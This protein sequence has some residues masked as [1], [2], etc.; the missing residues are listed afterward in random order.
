MSPHDS[1]D[2]QTA[3]RTLHSLLHAPL[4]G[5]PAWRNVWGGG[6][7]LLFLFVL[8]AFTG[9][10]MMTVY[11]PSATTAWSSVWYIQTQVPYGW[12]IRGLH[13]FGSDAMLV[14]IGLHCLQMSM[15]GAY[16]TPRQWVWWLSL[17]LC[18]LALC[19][20]LTGHLLPWDQGGYWSTKVRTNIVARTPLMGEALR[21]LLIGGSELGQLTLT[22]FY[23]LHV[24]VIP[25]LVALFMAFR[26]ALDT[27]ENVAKGKP[28]ARADEGACRSGQLLRGS[29]VC[30]GV[31]IT[32]LVLLWYVRGIAGSELLDAPADPA[33]ADYPAR[34]EWHTLFLYKWLS[35]F[36]GPLGG[37][38]GAIAV[39][40]VVIV[41]FFA[42]PFLDRVLPPRL[43]RALALGSVGAL[44]TGA[45]WLTVLA[46]R[47]DLNP[48]NER[49]AAVKARQARGETLTADHEAILR[50]RRFN[51]RRA[52]ARQVAARAM[53][54]AAQKGVPPQG[55]LEL[56]ANDPLTR[57][58]ELFAVHCAGCHRLNGQDGLGNVPPEPAT[59]S[60][61]DGYATRQW[62]RGL[63]SDPMG[64][65][66]F[67]R[68]V[69]PDGH[70]AHTR[71]SRWIRETLAANHDEDDRR[72]LL[73]DF[74]AVAAYLEDESIRPG[75]LANLTADKPDPLAERPTEANEALIIQGR[76][77]FMAVCNECHRYDGQHSGTFKAPE[78]RGYGSVEW[79]AL[80]I[81]N[82]SHDSRYRSR[83]REPAQMPS[84]EDKLPQ[85]DRMLIAQ[86]LHATRTIEP[87]N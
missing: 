3:P 36:E 43:A 83:G 39:P 62:I 84:F 15:T 45:A 14:V 48:S 37:V 61:L 50:A 86:W 27:K 71:M 74:D 29:L 1:A 81:A 40:G 54:L 70:P 60:D 80:M 17:S 10:L 47:A 79:I 22:R 20:S 35:Y 69:K 7:I 55:P 72:R 85:R 38:I 66:Y 44:S 41:L 78:M 67:G 56:L 19:L 51:Q 11:S 46:I 26:A 6:G 63:L 25:G 32:L 64:E 30:A 2:N 82:P 33:A 75:R 42:F 77:F 13:H 73:E 53:L 21:R 57:G 34:P 68:M 18:G 24:M 31:L 28:I 9:V 58:P 16:R 5:V 4:W 49:V 87:S 65:T 12:L 59:S 23:T 8:Q 76:R 52:R